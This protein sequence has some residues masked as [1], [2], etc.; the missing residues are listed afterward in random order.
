MN[1]TLSASLH[2][3]LDAHSRGPRLGTFSDRHPMR[4]PTVPWLDLRPKSEST[5]DRPRRPR[6]EDGGLGGVKVTIP[7]FK[8][9]SD[10]KVYLE[11]EMR[12][13]QIF[14]CHNYL[15]SKKDY[16]D[17]FLDE[18][19]PGLPLIRGI[20]H[21]IDFIIGTSL[22]NRP[23]YRTNPEE[24]KEIQRQIQEWMTKGYVRQSLSPC[25]VPVLLV[26]KKD[27]TWRM[28]VDCRAINN[29]ITIRYRHPI[30]R[31]DNMLDELNDSTIFSKLNFKSGY[32]QIRMK[33]KENIFADVLSRSPS[34]GWDKFYL[35]DGFLFEANQLCVPNCSVRS[36]LLKEVHSEGL[37]GR[38]GISKT[39]GVLSEHFY[40]PR[41]HRDVE[42]YV[43]RC[44]VCH[45]AK[46]KLNPHGLYMPLPIPSVPWEDV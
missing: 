37:M 3:T 16:E 25:V 1:A 17:I 20:D 26:P 14:S 19:P 33:G 21:Q 38:F 42:N 41:M 36:L 2:R 45:T 4:G 29:N 30:P 13:E 46:S 34:I 18:I 15:E 35:H 7:S 23:A 11:W 28:C 32:H 27:G 10:L 31:I 43:G 24:S 39:L 9:N 6:E 22:P 8:G 44:I 5:E 12:V 40:W